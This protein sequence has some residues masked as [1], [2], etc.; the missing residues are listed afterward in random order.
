[1]DRIQSFYIYRLLRSFGGFNVGSINHP[2]SVLV[3]LGR[4]WQ[5]PQTS[6]DI[7]S[8]THQRRY[9][10]RHRQQNACSRMEFIGFSNQKPKTTH[11]IPVQKSALT[12]KNKI[13]AFNTPFSSRHDAHFHKICIT[14]RIVIYQVDQEQNCL[15]FG[16]AVK[17]L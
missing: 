17:D 2:S 16:N 1:M 7:P 9:P 15:P 13:L 3:V 14:K 4:P 8:G 12:R 10:G 11:N 6:S 5:F